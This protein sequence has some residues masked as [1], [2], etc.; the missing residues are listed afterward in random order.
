MR[1]HGL[2]L[3]RHTGR[4]RP[5]EQD[6][7]V[8]TIRSNCRW[9]SDALK[10]T[11][12]NGEVVR[13]AFAL[14]C[15]ESEVMLQSAVSAMSSPAPMRSRAARVV[16]YSRDPGAGQASAFGRLCRHFPD[17]RYAGYNKGRPQAGANRAKAE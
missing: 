1:K 6:G 5:R 7:Q 15:H 11:C 8:A 12:S 4:Q 2:L 13:V 3:E 10:F 16:Y 14:A 9:C 17:R